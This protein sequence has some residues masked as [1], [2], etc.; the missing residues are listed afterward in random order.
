MRELGLRLAQACVERKGVPGVA[1]M[2][3][4]V[5][6]T[7]RRAPTGVASLCAENT[8]GAA[9]ASLRRSAGGAV[10]W[11]CGGRCTHIDKA[12]PSV[13]HRQV[14]ALRRPRFRP[15]RA[16]SPRRQG[17]QQARRQQP[18]RQRTRGG[19]R[20]LPRA[21]SV[22][23][24]KVHPARSRAQRHQQR[25]RPPRPRVPPA[26]RVRHALPRRPAPPARRPPRCCVASRGAHFV[27]ALPPQLSAWPIRP[28]A[29]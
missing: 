21:P 16:G 11:W 2:P 10:P 20:A 9:R 28:P 18:R 14:L 4:P 24:H 26:T 12:A 5:R 7:A 6:S 25:H 22:S 23:V 1:E 15:S 19:R 17:L 29:N 13:S 3:L 27:R 8:R